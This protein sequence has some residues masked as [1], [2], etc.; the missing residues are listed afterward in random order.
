VPL[1]LPRTSPYRIALD[2][3]SPWH[4]SAVLATAIETAS[5]P[6]RLKD[7]S[8]GDT[9]D[10]MTDL[11]NTMGKQTVATLQMSYP[12]A[13]QEPESDS[14]Q[15]KRTQN[16][17]ANNHGETE[18]PVHLD[19]DFAPDTT[20]QKAQRNGH[21]GHAESRIF[22]QL[23]VVRGE[24][25]E[26]EDYDPELWDELRHRRQGGPVL[27]QYHTT[28]AFPLPSSFPQVFRD[29]EGLRLD[30]NGAR[31]KASLTTDSSL[32]RRLRDLR[33]TVS[34]SFAIEDRETLGNDLADM[35][36]EYH[37]GWSSGS[38]VGMDD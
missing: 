34:R 21:N 2:L 9:L 18:Q 5:L 13:L 3:T 31:L 12:N 26:E 11:L 17:D 6:S 20:V 35:A 4:T 22:S 36:D 10:T 19:L 29:E 14:R 32:S 30:G 37:E 24:Y 25:S 27:R 38:D 7:R 15:V 33:A 28:C 1:A 23:S 16:S 8:K